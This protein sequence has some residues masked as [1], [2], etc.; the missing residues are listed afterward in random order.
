MSAGA[1][2]AMV[3]VDRRHTTSSWFM[4]IP[5]SHSNGLFIFVYI[6]RLVWVMIYGTEQVVQHIH[7]HSSHR[8]RDNWRFRFDKRE[9]ENS[10]EITA[11]PVCSE[12]ECVNHMYR[13]TR[14]SFWCESSV[15]FIKKLIRTQNTSKWNLNLIYAQTI[16]CQ[17]CHTQVKRS[18]THRS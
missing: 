14:R 6:F 1:T 12:V 5:L 9:K 7:T 18:N 11:T 3:S 15:S 13:R 4:N 17:N 8:I 2:M 10:V 16:K